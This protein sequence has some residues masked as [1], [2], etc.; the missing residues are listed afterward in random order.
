MSFS[1]QFLP[2]RLTAAALAALVTCATAT[3]APA[4]PLPAQS[5]EQIRARMEVLMRQLGNLSAYL[6]S[7]GDGKI[8][9]KN[10]FQ[11]AE[12]LPKLPKPTKPRE[13]VDDKQLALMIE[14]IR[15]ANTSLAADEHIDVRVALPAPACMS[16][17]PKK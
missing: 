16:K 15:T 9:V 5:P 6:E 7:V 11:K 3:A 13:P 10:F 12:C 1:L 4:T 8:V 2:A 14:A 17:P